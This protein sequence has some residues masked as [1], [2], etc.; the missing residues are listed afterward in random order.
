MNSLAWKSTACGLG[1]LLSVVGCSAKTNSATGSATAPVNSTTSPTP[2]SIEPEASTKPKAA[3]Y[4][5]QAQVEGYLIEELKLTDLSLT[6]A[7]GENYT[8]TGTGRDGNKY[9]LNVKQ[10]P[11]GIACDF[12]TDIGGGKV[13]FGNP[14]P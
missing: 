7:G 5:S 1:I 12:T 4:W 9:R 14:V 6:R 13:S 2:E 8:G 10:V 11:G 3:G